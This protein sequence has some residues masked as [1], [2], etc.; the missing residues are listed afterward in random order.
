MTIT[1]SVLLRC[2]NALIS[3]ARY[4]FDTLFMA[5]GIKVEYVSKPPPLGIWILYGSTKETPLPLERCLTIAHCPDCW[6]FFNGNTDIESIGYV[7]QLATVFPQKIAH[8]DGTSDIAFDLIV[9][10]FYFLSSWSERLITNKKETRSLYATSIF[11]RLNIPQDIVDQYLNKLIDSLNNL[12][13]R[14]NIESLEPLDWPQHANHA[15]VLSHDVDFIPAGQMDI[16]KQGAKTI[17]RH[18]IRQRDPVDAIYAA[19]GLLSALIRK[20]DPYGCLPEIIKREKELGVN[21]SFQVAVGHRHVN[22]VNYFIENDQTRDYLKCIVDEGLDL[23]LHGSYRSTEEIDWYYEEMVLLTERLGKPL[24]SRQHFLSFDYDNL[25]SAQE[26]SGIQYDMSMGFPD[27]VGPRTGFSYPYYPYCLSEDRPY[28]VLELNL[29]L[30]DVTLRGYLG[31]K[32]EK[33]WELIQKTLDDLS[34]KQG[35][36]SV[37]W[38]PIVFG[39]ARDPGFDNLF[40][41]LITYTK[42]NNGFVTDGRT[43]N[44]FWRNNAK[45]YS[46]FSK[47]NV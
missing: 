7:E 23:C 11:A 3:K 9:N 43:L 45:T 35:C 1:L 16:V 33:A 39:G 12:C 18:L 8:F 41:Q 19:K 29:F 20:R 5:K 40:W 38:H 28:D 34:I 46:S 2:D 22:D 27:Q 44:H 30:M 6:G 4:V 37:V 14:R 42:E 25:F 15:L 26:K 13:N 36:A 10:S 31:L 24:G 47:K 32:G 21:A 17:L